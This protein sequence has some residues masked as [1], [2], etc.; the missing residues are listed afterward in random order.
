MR[1]SLMLLPLLLGGCSCQ[2][3]ADDAGRSQA[4]TQSTAQSARDDARRSQ[5]ALRSATV[6]ALQS[7]DADADKPDRVIRNYVDALLKGSAQ[8]SDAFWSGG[9]R[10]PRADDDLLRDMRD[11]RAVRVDIEPPYA[12]DPEQAPDLLQANV[13]VRV[14]SS[15]GVHR[16]SGYY[17]LQPAADG[18]AWQLYAVSLHAVLD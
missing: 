16:F 6:A 12:L 3:A 8:A 7:V 14:T 17:R 1:R 11:I 10:P 18:S 9:Q 4:G 15:E 5:Q 2:R 13:R